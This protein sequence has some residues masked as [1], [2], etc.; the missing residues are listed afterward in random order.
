MAKVR[1]L[2]EGRNAFS[3]RQWREAF[4]SF[5]KAD[6]HS[7]LGP[8]DLEQLGN[9]AYLIGKDDE[10]IA[11]WTRAYNEFVEQGDCLH[12]ARLGFWLCLSLML[13][14][15]GAQS[16]GWLSRTERLISSS[17]GECAEHGYMLVVSGLF[18]LFKGD[19]A[20]SCSCFE[21]ATSLANRFVDADLLAVSVLS[22]GQAL[23]QMQRA[24]EGVVLLD[25][26]MVAVIS[27]QVSPIMAGI[28]Y[29]AVILTCE[30][31]HDLQRAHEWTVALDQWCGS[32]PELVAFRGQCL[33]HH[34]D[35]MQ[36]RGDWHKALEE[37][38]RACELLSGKSERM[39]GR[40][41]YQ[42]AELHR[43]SGDLKH[44]DE[45]YRAAGAKGFEPQPGVSL[46]RL[47]QGDVKAATA[48]I[49]RVVNEAQC[50]QVLGEGVQRFKVLGPFVEIMLAAG[51]L[52]SART[53]ADELVHIATALQ[54]PLVKATSAQM[55]GA[56]LL[57]EGHP[58]Q[59]L[60]PLREAW[61]LWQKLEAPYDSARVR[62]FIGRACQMLHDGDTAK[63]HLDAAAL[64]FER[65]GAA[66]E[67]ARLRASD[68]PHRGAQALFTGRERQ[69][70]ALVASGKSNREIAAD[71]GISEHTVARH[72]SNIFNKTGVSSRTAASAF[73]FENDLV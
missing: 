49:R 72:I 28:I 19:G 40:A 64:I 20:G 71:L 30:R 54:M 10:A 42:Q 68:L 67:L 25:E 63:L 24:E 33:L 23:V 41:L 2:D 48:S 50:Q 55:T 6:S 15:K 59:A 21:Q 4:V 3:R 44:A 13:G 5:S 7:S 58:E 52:E 18:A 47:A 62:V 26:A 46:L 22:R 9:A 8:L 14:G 57:A 34:S 53:A 65:L 61:T 1:A 69:V 11:T 45:L 29:C 16:S 39:V 12:A 73:A 43:R 27:G 17:Q 32:Q 31:V 38:E 36:I 35:L 66:P 51:E 60:T 56:V 37:A 70:L